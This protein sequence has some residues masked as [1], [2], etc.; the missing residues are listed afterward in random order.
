[1]ERRGSLA[2]G[3]RGGAKAP[4]DA[5][6]PGATAAGFCP[7]AQEMNRASVLV[8]LQDDARGECSVVLI[9]RALGVHQH[10]GQVA[11]P[12]GRYEPA[13]DDSLLATALREAEEEIGL[14]AGAVALL[15]ALP[16]R[17]TLSSNLLVSPFVGRIPSGYPLHP[18]KGEVARIFAAPLAH[19][20]TVQGREQLAWGYEGRT[21]WVPCVRVEGEVVWGL[22]LDIIDE[23]IKSGLSWNG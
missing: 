15:G 2:E 22:T 9:R 19:F 21:Y 13:R 17:R 7:G 10:Q 11:F 4:P 6:D 1:M 16:E 5:E 14:A 18:A 23:L 12:G 20:A 8:P 3:R